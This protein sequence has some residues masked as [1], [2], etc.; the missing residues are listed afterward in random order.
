M[1]ALKTRRAVQHNTTRVCWTLTGTQAIDGYADLP[2]LGYT[3]VIERGTRLFLHPVGEVYT[4][5]DRGMPPMTRTLWATEADARGALSNHLGPMWSNVV[6]IRPVKI[7]R[8]TTET[9]E[10]D[11]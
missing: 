7:V 11:E 2:T 10:W 8:T 1:S 3:R 9:I 6:D 5:W 4:M